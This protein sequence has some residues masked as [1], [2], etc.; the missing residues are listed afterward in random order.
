MREALT[1]MKKSLDQ[2]IVDLK[3]KIQELRERELTVGPEMTLSHFRNISVIL[4]L[5]DGLT[6][7]REQ[8]LL[9]GLHGHH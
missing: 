1:N 8:D 6:P 3:Q 7:R 4:L 2:E 9:H 5:Q